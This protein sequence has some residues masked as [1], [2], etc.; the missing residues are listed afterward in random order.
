MNFQWKQNVTLVVRLFSWKA[1]MI[2]YINPKTHIQTRQ[3]A[4]FGHAHYAK[5]KTI[6]TY[7]ED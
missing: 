2:V 5:I 1:R 4:I 3:N 7:S 6:F